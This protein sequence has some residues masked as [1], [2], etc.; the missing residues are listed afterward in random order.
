MIP[1]DTTPASHFPRTLATYIL[2]AL[3][4]LVPR[5][6][7][8]G[9]F[10][11]HDEVEFWLTRSETFLVALQ[12]GDYAATAI[13]TH[14]GV[15]TMWLG[16]IGIGLRRALRAWHIVE[17]VQFPLLLAL[18]RLPVVLTHV[19]GILVGY[20]MLRRMFSAGIALFA[21]L[22][23]ATDPFV[24]G[25]SRLLHVD[26][27]AGTFMTLSILAACLY[28][29]HTR[30]TRWLVLSAACA[31][32][33]LL[34]K[35]PS[36]L[37]VPFVGT[38]ALV[39]TMQA[40]HHTSLVSRLRTSVLD[41]LIWGAVCALTIVLVWPAVWADPVRVYD[42]LR[43]GVEV[44]G[45]NPHMT[46]NFF[47]GHEDPAPGPLFYPVALVLRTTPWSLVGLLLLPLAIWRNPGYQQP[48]DNDGE[49]TTRHQ[50]RT[51]V[52]L[53]MFVVLFTAA[54]SIF[55]KKFNRYLVPVFPSLDILAAVGLAWVGTYMQESLRSLRSLWFNYAFTPRLKQLAATVILL[56]GCINAAWIHP[57]AIT[58]FNQ[59]FGG[60]P[61]GARTFSIGWGEGFDQVAAWLNQQLDI[62]GVVTAAIMVNALNPYLRHG[63][64]A[65]TP[66]G[67]TLPDSAGYV[68]VYVY[69]AQGTVFP[70][71]DDYYA[72]KTP[73][74]TI[75]IHGIE[76][77]W[78][79]QVPPPVAHARPADFGSAIHLRGFD[80]QAEPQRGSPLVCKLFWQ[81]NAPPTADYWLFAHVVGED[82]QR[83]SQVD[84][85]YNTS[86]W[87]PHRFT[88]TELQLPIPAD[89]PLGTYHILLGMY[90]PVNNMRL[91]LSSDFAADPA[92]YGPDALVLDSF[93]R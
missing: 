93:S 54:M 6:F 10:V 71:F 39:G 46:G 64:Q 76:Y 82:G 35:S 59:V 90:D 58:Y 23:W 12:T 25:Y 85:P 38:L 18:M 29:N 7:D 20:A 1:D 47:L 62:T 45:S 21:A 44:E 66:R 40:S 81:T 11:T 22:L 92:V 41:M 13:S 89:L 55:P 51:L 53:A 19:V 83:Y 17:E 48:A 63:A 72:H 26:A 9:S 5:L 68:V 31:G 24:I 37:L 65:T 60:P 30:H 84:M 27:L 79:Y 4:A 8:L 70:P 75:T 50:I 16:S 52:V 33:A 67:E 77:A 14:P 61:A 28:W 87:Q 78:I 86:T 36:L 32:L 80:V 88:T 2:V 91:P 74:H 3:V 49:T 56:A 57:Y 73:L 69:Q 15:T 43:I 34:S 42:L